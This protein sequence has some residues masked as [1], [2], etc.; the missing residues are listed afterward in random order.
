M[1]NVVSATTTF[2]DMNFSLPG[3]DLFQLKSRGGV[4]SSKGGTIFFLPNL[5]ENNK[6]P[7]FLVTGQLNNADQRKRA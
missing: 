4:S 5:K 6:P 1:H 2:Y 7:P 3:C